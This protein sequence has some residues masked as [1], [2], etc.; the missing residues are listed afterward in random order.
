MPVNSVLRF[1]AG[2]TL[3]I[4]QGGFPI[5]SYTFSAFW[6]LIVFLIYIY[7]HPCTWYGLRV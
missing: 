3:L 5:Q 6:Q 1:L 2:S 4:F 7:F